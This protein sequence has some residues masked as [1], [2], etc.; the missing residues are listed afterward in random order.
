M[1]RLKHFRRTFPKDSIKRRGVI[2]VLTAICLVMLLGFVALTVDI[3]FLM[4]TKT[5]LQAAA[6]GSIL[7]GALELPDGWGPGKVS[8]T[9]QV[10]TATGT[11]T[12]TVAATYKVGEMPSAYIDTTRDL[13]FGQRTQNA[14]GAWVETWGTSPYNMV[15]VTVR[16]DQP[17]ANGIVTRGDQQIP[18]LFAPII[19]SS[20]SSVTAKAT[21]VLVPGNGFYIPPS[22]GLTCPLLPIALDETT[23][24]NLVNNGIGS[25][26]YRYNATTKTVSSGADG[27]KEVSLY[28]NGTNTT[29]GNRGTV[30]IGSSNNST[31]DLSR[32][33]RN[34]P[35]E[36][37]LA[38]FGGK[39]QIPASGLLAL[40]GDTGLSA[41]IKDDLAAIIGQPRA[42]PIFRSVSGPGNNA[43]YQIC[44]FV[45]IRILFV[46][47]TGSPSGKTV[48]VQPA[49][50]F[51]GTITSSPGVLQ[52]D[53]IMVSLR[54]VH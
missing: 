10:Q 19:G 54:L 14:Q 26:N 36:A 3:G 31:A 9:T 21:A 42:I 1:I 30:D 50:V 33:I 29:A 40:N 49:P 24:N 43:T 53:S 16:R 7:S 12:Q 34:G 52:P 28:P 32:Q 2:I 20:Y 5:Q 4:Q 15:E 51:D 6:D 48:V 18:L 45:G 46:R 41:G 39:V 35:N 27:I 23:W 17:L 11:V 25:D 13:R 47:L 44:K 8:T 38:Y 22:S 37:D